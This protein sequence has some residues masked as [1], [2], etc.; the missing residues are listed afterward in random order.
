M[1]STMRVSTI[2]A[3]FLA[4]FAIACD[5]QERQEPAKIPPSEA[6]EFH[7]K[8]AISLPDSTHFRLIDANGEKRTLADWK[9]KIVLLFFGYTHCPDACPT[10]LFRA[11]QVMDILGREAAQVQVLFVSLDPTRDTPDVLKAYASAFHPSFQGLSVAPEDLPSLAQT[12]R[13][14]YRTQSGA[15]A[16]SYSI[17]HSVHTYVYDTQN[18]LRLS[19]PYQ[20]TPEEMAEDIK[21]LLAEQ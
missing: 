6:R 7:G 11:A 5:R 10:T 18:R 17:D 21:T 8:E 4:F 14:I 15:D 9:G 19:I 16:K 1:L 12:F 3:L 13:I 2:L 20:A